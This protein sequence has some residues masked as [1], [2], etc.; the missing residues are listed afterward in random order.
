MIEVTEKVLSSQAHLDQILGDVYILSDAGM[1]ILSILIIL[2]FLLSLL[3]FAKTV[4]L[5]WEFDK[6]KQVNDNSFQN[7]RD[8]IALLVE[9]KISVNDQE[10]VNASRQLLEII[11]KRSKA[12]PYKIKD[13]V[14]AVV[15]NYD[16]EDEYISEDEYTSD[17][18]EDSLSSNEGKEEDEETKGEDSE[19]N[20][21]DVTKK[22]IQQTD[23][24]SVE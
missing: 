4:V 23:I 3:F 7:I 12:L 2:C 24:D 19:E 13:N 22:E 6:I 20:C 21:E 1:I 16:S 15:L 18:L 10:F 5:S 8:W 14:S 17:D 9:H 11:D